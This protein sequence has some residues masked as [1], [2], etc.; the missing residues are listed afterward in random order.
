MTLSRTEMREPPGEQL[1][2]Q[3][4]TLVFYIDDTGDEQLNNQQH[5]IFALGGVAC[6]TEHHIP[7][8]RAWQIM[9]TS[10]FPQ[11]VGPL[12]AKTH[13]R[14]RMTDRRCRAVL[15]G[16]AHRQLGRFGAV[17]TSS[18]IIPLDKVVPVACGTLFNRI[19]NVTDGMIRLG[20]W[21]PVGGQIVTVF[22]ASA[23]LAEHIQLGFAGRTIKAGAFTI[24]IDGCFMPKSVANP[25][26][27]MADFVA[28]TIGKNL[29]HQIKR[30]P[31]E[32]TANFRALFR[33]VGPPLA[34]YIE[35]RMAVVPET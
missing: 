32:C 33:D 22:E 7:I 3:R 14:D 20:L 16:M 12:H 19:A 30:S 31:A 25:F 9:K 4:N 10:T 17:I 21:Q 1:V 24:P 26:L 23:R 27:E 35:V 6:V 8:A 2:I 15:A 11:V 34:D 13:L 29:K 5:P 18:T 28:N